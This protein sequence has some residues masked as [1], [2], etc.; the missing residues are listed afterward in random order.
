[1]RRNLPS[2]GQPLDKE[3]NFTNTIV[4]NVYSNPGRHVQLLIKEIQSN[5]M[6]INVCKKGALLFGALD[7]SAADQVQTL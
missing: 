5:T 3:G 1:M 6:D 2:S 4:G 7:G